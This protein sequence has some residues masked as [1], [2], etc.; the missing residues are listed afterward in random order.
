MTTPGTRGEAVFDI[1]R[2]QD[3]KIAEHWNVSQNVPET[4]ANGNGMFSTESLPRTRHPGPAWLTT[5]SK[6][7]VTNAFDEIAGQ[8]DPSRPATATDPPGPVQPWAH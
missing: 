6:K 5:Y 7:L 1:F 2:F 4:S 8:R 3:G